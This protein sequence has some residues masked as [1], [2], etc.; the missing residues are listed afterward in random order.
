METG[1]SESARS[2]ATRARQSQ[3]KV[4]LKMPLQSFGKVCVLSSFEAIDLETNGVVPDC[5]QHRHLGQG[6]ADNLLSSRSDGKRPDARSV[7]PLDR[8]RAKPAITLG[9]AP[10]WKPRTSSDP[11]LSFLPGGPRFKSLQLVP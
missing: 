10:I 4:S 3:G 11:A 1:R 2:K 8:A 6:A 5:R 7:V 9:L